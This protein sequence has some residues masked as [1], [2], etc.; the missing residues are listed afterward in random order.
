MATAFLILHRNNV[1]YNVMLFTTCFN[2]SGVWI[3]KQ[4]RVL[5]DLCCQSLGLL[6][7]GKGC[8]CRS[9]FSCPRVGEKSHIMTFHSF[10]QTTIISVSGV[11]TEVTLGCRRGH[12][13]HRSRGGTRM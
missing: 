12:V 2:I 7:L 10:Q 3:R 4:V 9:R 6:S 8:Q 1:F 5:R 11:L 13:G